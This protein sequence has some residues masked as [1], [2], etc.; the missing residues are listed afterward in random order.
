MCRGEQLRQTEPSLTKEPLPSISS[1]HW[2]ALWLADG[3]VSH[4]VLTAPFE[5][6]RTLRLLMSLQRW[7]DLISQVY[8]IKLF[9]VPIARFCVDTVKQPLL[10]NSQLTAKL[11]SSNVGRRLVSSSWLANANSYRQALMGGQSCWQPAR[12]PLFIFVCHIL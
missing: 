10:P 8:L 2:A 1:P 12:K 4:G 6:E 11:S 5:K 7:F 9:I 3:S